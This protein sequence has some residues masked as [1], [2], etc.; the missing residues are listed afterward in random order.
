MARVVGR[1][2]NSAGSGLADAGG[3]LSVR[4]VRSIWGI[5]I[6]AAFL[7]VLVDCP[8]VRCGLTTWDF[9]LISPGAEAVPNGNVAEWNF[10]AAKAGLYQLAWIYQR[11]PGTHRECHA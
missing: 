2:G 11:V 4:A 8:V 3:G 7:H 6:L 1:R 9:T 5:G 10:R